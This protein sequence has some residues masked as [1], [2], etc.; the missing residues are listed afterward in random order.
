[1]FP[2]E[3]IRLWPGFTL[4]FFKPDDILP[5]RSA[6][7]AAIQILE[8]ETDTASLR[9]P[10][11]IFGTSR[12]WNVAQSGRLQYPDDSPQALE[13][14]FLLLEQLAE[15][16]RH[17]S[18]SVYHILHY[19]DSQIEGDR[20][21]GYLRHRLQ[22]LFG[23][24]GPG[25]L[26]A[27][28]MVP[29]RNIRQVASDNWLRYLLYGPPEYRAP[30]RRYGIMMARARYEGDTAGIY[31][32]RS[33]TGYSGVRQAK[34]LTLLYEG[35]DSS[36]TL[37][38]T[39]G[40][41]TNAYALETR[42]PRELQLLRI[43]V[44]FGPD[45]LILRFRGPSPEIFGIALDG[46]SGIQVDNIPMR[47]ASGTF[48]RSADSL[49]F[50]RQA[51]ALNVRLV[52]MEFGGN[53]LPHIH[54]AEE[55]ERY[56]AIME[57]QFRFVRQAI[58]KASL[59]VIGPADMAVRYEGRLQT[60]PWLEAV[61]DALRRAAFRAG[62]AFWDMYAAMGGRQSMQVWTEAQPPLASPDFIH[63]T[64]AGAEKIAGMFTSALVEDFNVWRAARMR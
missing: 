24:S 45:G 28:Q 21:S 46:N 44:H 6:P 33:V 7:Q 2:K 37:E 19:G 43:P 50:A 55:A 4:R 16:S 57:K 32:F 3:G 15:T 40:A 34:I 25:L 12:A 49:L 5:A 54:S 56:G 22:N 62:A 36:T 53:M 48:F 47:G 14:F 20:I 41:E 8:T 17:R 31:L 11:T 35:S 13:P 29:A 1:M 64:P 18:D 10:T 63:F 61:R 51:E 52:I 23:G 42:R 30:D 26:P 38:L 39:D 27:V 58:P 59:I 9:D 60:H